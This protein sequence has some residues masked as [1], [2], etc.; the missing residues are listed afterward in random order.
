MTPPPGS[1]GGWGSFEFMHGAL[2]R[3]GN[4]SR[5]V[6]ITVFLG[7][8]PVWFS[9]GFR[10]DTVSSSA[11][12]HEILH[13]LKKKGKIQRS[14]QVLISQTQTFDLPQHETTSRALSHRR[15]H[16]HC[17][18]PE[19]SKLLRNSSTLP[20]TKDKTHRTSQTHISST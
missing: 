15:N 11:Q 16:P 6:F 17:S 8:D 13:N 7:D 20:P 4:I 18:R 14:H 2:K 19:I 1:A 9:K 3:L 12:E 10:G 5:A